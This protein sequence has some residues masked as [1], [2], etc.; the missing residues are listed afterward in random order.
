MKKAIKWLAVVGL[1]MVLG[2]AL[3]LNAE[4]VT[5]PVVKA[6]ACPSIETMAQMLNV[7]P[8]ELM[9]ALEEGTFKDLLQAHGLTPDGFAAMITEQ[10]RL[11]LRQAYEAGQIP[12]DRYQK[13]T[14]ALDTELWR[15]NAEMVKE[16][17]DFPGGDMAALQ[18][19]LEKTEM[20]RIQAMQKEGL[21]CE[22][23]AAQMQ[24]QFRQMEQA[25]LGGKNAQGKSMQENMQEKQM[26]SSPSQKPAEK[27]APSNNNSGSMNNNNASPKNSR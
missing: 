19:Q 18:K 14:K 3:A 16:M 20:A 24:Q 15:Y 5:S 21:I 22:S 2:G 1:A 4:P 26:P 25:M 13:L 6:L 12:D 7:T 11:Q 10:M 27:P 23:E 8:E 9:T 17:A